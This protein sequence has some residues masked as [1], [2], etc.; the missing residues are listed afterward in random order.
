MEDEIL[1][2]TKKAY[3]EMKNQKHSFWEK[4]K[5]IFIEILIIVFAVTIS[6][7]LHGWDEHRQE[8]KEVKE[9][10][11][12]LKDNLQQDIKSMT[13]TRDSVTKKNKD[14]Y[15]FIEIS[16]NLKDTANKKNL[17][18]SFS[19]GIVTTKI[20]DG[21]YEGFKSSGKIGYIENKKLKKAILKYYQETTPSI[22]ELEKANTTEIL[23]IIDYVI[24]NNNI[25]INLFKDVKLKLMLNFYLQESETIKSQYD[26][27]VQ[28][29]QGIINE[30]GKEYKN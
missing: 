24:E 15:D 16:N 4:A 13:A 30:I 18:Y 22:L 7:W 25:G 14:Y 26:D 29:A 17:S 8:Q 19:T 28:Q 21:D 23:K 11:N 5:E 6:I 12:D 27:A 3:Y 1:K 2:H 20:S 10:L 9:F